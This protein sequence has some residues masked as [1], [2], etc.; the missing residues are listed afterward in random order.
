MGMYWKKRN[1]N[2]RGRGYGHCHRSPSSSIDHDGRE[3]TA[4]WSHMVNVYSKLDT[5]VTMEK[6]LE[7]V[8]AKIK[9]FDSNTHVFSTALLTISPSQYGKSLQILG[10]S[11]DQKQNGGTGEVWDASMNTNVAVLLEV[12]ACAS[13]KMFFDAEFHCTALRQS[14]E[15]FGHQI[16]KGFETRSWR[17]TV[18]W[19]T[20]KHSQTQ[21]ITQ[22]WLI[23]ANIRARSPPRGAVPAVFNFIKDFE[24]WNSRFWSV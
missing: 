13:V 12:C 1:F 21:A 14:F 23:L 3:I 11:E 6:L 22:N 10:W 8:E 24:L 5:C 9:E 7:S 4:T 18:D 2:N 17:T 19:E 20:G 16:S 15:K